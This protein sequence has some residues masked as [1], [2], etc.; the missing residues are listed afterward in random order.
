MKDFIKQF[1]QLIYISSAF[2]IM[3]FVSSCEGPE[4]PIGAAG[5]QGPQ[6]IAGQTGPT[7]PAGNPGAPGVA[8]VFA[9]SWINIIWTN[10]PDRTSESTIA[11]PNITA[12]TV[13]EDMV[14]VYWRTS[15]A[16]TNAT[17]LPNNFIS[18]QTFFFT[19]RL[20]FSI[21]PGSVKLFTGVPILNTNPLGAAFPN[22]QTRY[23]I[24]KGGNTGRM[25][26]NIDFENY[27]EVCAYFGIEP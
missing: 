18:S 3:L 9:S 20:E 23:I 6:G 14:L 13:Q 4:G 25:D 10:N 1:R 2:V 27:E 24:V 19:V 7:G 5:P 15:S 17:P 26:F 11:A 16:A 8:N 12:T 22:S 21:Q